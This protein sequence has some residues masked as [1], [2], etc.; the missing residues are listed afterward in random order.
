MVIQE[1]YMSVTQAAAALEV[2]RATITRWVKE[3]KLSGEKIGL[4][5]LISRKEIQRIA[6]ERGIL[7]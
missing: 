6:E 5:T 3:G 2:N 1:Q 7:L 4:F